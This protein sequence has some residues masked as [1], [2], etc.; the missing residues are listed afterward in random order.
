M[1]FLN[2]W[3]MSSTSTTTTTTA[4]TTTTILT[5]TRPNPFPDNDVYDGDIMNGHATTDVDYD[6]DIVTGHATSTDDTL[7]GNQRQFLHEI[8]PLWNLYKIIHLD[9]F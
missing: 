8:I 3:M 2:Y 4:S 1:T 6:G 9:K 5:T 7:M